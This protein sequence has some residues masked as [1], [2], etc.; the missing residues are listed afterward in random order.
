MHY[1]E[2]LLTSELRSCKGATESIEG[3]GR[4]KK[5]P[6]CHGSENSSPEINNLTGNELSYSQ[7][8]SLRFLRCC[9]GKYLIYGLRVT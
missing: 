9:C 8:L 2:L 1:S 6:S 7:A 3:T 4:V 5:G